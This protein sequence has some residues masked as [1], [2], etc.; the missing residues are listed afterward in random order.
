MQDVQPIAG[1]PGVPQHLA[2]LGA[3]LFTAW[4]DHVDVALRS[5][6]ALDRRA[7]VRDQGVEAL[8][9]HER[10]ARPTDVEGV[11]AHGAEIRLPGGDQ[12]SVLAVD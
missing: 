11:L 1:H 12:P 9:E 5:P 8:D 4:S 2:G 3:Q 6:R 7:E 10:L